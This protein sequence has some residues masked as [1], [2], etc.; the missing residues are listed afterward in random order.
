MQHGG[1]FL[2]LVLAACG[3]P[4]PEKAVTALPA[5]RPAALPSPLPSAVPNVAMVT[6]PGGKWRPLFAGRDE[7]DQMIAPFALDE[8]PTTNAEFLAFVR[9][10][11]QW[12][13][14][15]V[16]R[17]FADERYLGQWSSDLEFGQHDPD[18]PVTNVSWFAA[19]AYAKWVGKRLPTFAEW[20]WAARDGVEDPVRTREILAWYARPTPKRFARVASGGRSDY[21]LFDMHGLVWEW[22][23]DYD[24]AMTS[25]ESRGDS[26]LERGLFCGSGALGAANPKDYAGFMR[27][28]FRSALRA[29]YCV[30]NLG[31]RCA[32]DLP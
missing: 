8:H 19:R 29:E 2:A 32:K 10:M 21:G 7:K 31:F 4:T 13:R 14:S 11:P 23:V 12:R 27:Y 9:S 16:K 17:L 1:I 6:V 3:G 5:S 20:E 15:Q 18:A 26:A 30:N 22:V 24:Q 25:G 28:A